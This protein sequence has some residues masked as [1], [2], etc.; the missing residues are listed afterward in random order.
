MR[1]PRKKFG[2]FPLDLEKS[3]FLACFDSKGLGATGE[4]AAGAEEASA[5]P[6]RVESLD[7]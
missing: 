2:D 7:A 4:A 3:S 5:I 6:R 1:T